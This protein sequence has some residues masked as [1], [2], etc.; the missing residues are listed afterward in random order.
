MNNNEIYARIEANILNQLENGIIPWRK[1][2]HVTENQLSISHQ[3]GLEYGMLNQFLLPLPGE[4]WTFNQAIKEGYHVRK[5]AKSSKIYFWSIVNRKRNNKDKEEELTPYANVYP[6]LREYSVF[7]ESDIEGLPPKPLNAEDEAKRIESAETIVSRYFDNNRWLNLF[8]CDSTP[9]FSP[10]HNFIKMPAIGQF[11]SIEEYYSALFH[12]MTHSTAIPLER[13][14][15]S[16]TK[17]EKELYA[18]EE[19][20]A[21]IG[22]AYLCGHAG[23]TEEQVISNSAS[24]CR[25]WLLS[26]KDNI[27]NLVWASS[28]AEA[29][30]EYILHN[31]KE[32]KRNADSAAE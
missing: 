12:E 19:L 28:R 30:V 22:A 9:S 16:K 31:N 5:G 13:Q 4:Y 11:D 1:C 14:I 27:K 26:L 8:T 3:S 7:H 32:R 17:N 15:G 20:V 2:Y 21:E 24:Y 10:S 6:I 18:K 23:I 25:G 29:A